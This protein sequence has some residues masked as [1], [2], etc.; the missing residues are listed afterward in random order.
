MASP[1]V[2][3]DVDNFIRRYQSGVSLKQL[4]EETGHSRC[5]LSRILRQN[6]IPIRNRSDGMRARWDTEKATPDW[7]ARLMATAW[8]VAD[9]RNVDVERKVVSMYRAGNAS[10]AAIARRLGL[11][12]PTVGGILRKNGIA[13]DRRLIRRAAGNVGGFNTASQCA[14]ETEFAAAMTVRSMDY[15]HQHAIGTRNVDFAFTA[16]G[17]AVEIVRRHW[18]DAKSLRR[19]RL[20]QIV[21]AGW[22]LWIVYDPNQRGIAVDAC[23]NHLV[24]CLDFACGNPSAPG[25]YWMIDSQGKPLAARRPQLHHL[26]AIEEPLA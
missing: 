25:Q 9:A 7:Q 11:A 24:A 12:K 6:N 10:Q 5:A 1:I 20:E 19:E 4:A 18:N 16:A 17:V 8:A 23:L 3:H 13:N 14:I 26:A 21:S 2:L 15:I 22:R